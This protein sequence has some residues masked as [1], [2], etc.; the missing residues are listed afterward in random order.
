MSQL[1]PPKL[2]GLELARAMLE[3]LERVQ[4]HLTRQQT[5][6]IDLLGGRGGE[7]WV[8]EGKDYDVVTFGKFTRLADL[9]HAA[10]VVAQTLAF[11]AED[12]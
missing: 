7:L 2:T 5:F 12:K 11:I 10:N 3:S 1:T 8:F 9:P 4:R 6:S